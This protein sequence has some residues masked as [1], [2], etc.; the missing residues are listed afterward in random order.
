MRIGAIAMVM[1][2][3]GCASLRPACP[4]GQSAAREVRLVFGRNIAGA[5]GVSEADFR[6]FM[7]AELTPRFPDG[8]T[9]IDAQG[10]WRGASA[11][12][13]REPSKLVILVLPVGV[14]DAGAKLE[15]A[16]AAYKVRF[17][18]ESVMILSQPVCAGF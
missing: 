7:D 9:V 5:P 12:V 6:G 10:Q 8:L 4:A 11:A 15:A 14:K 16:R 2:L 17:R 3:G 13:E 18:Q 1:A